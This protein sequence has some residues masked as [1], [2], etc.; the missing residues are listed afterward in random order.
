MVDDSCSWADLRHEV[1]VVFLDTQLMSKA[2]KSSA[3]RHK[4]EEVS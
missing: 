4:H 1:D 2:I 3:P